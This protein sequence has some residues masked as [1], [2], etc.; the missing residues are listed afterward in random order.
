MLC[1]RLVAEGLRF[2][3]FQRGRDG[4]FTADRV[5]LAGALAED[6]KC[7]DTFFQVEAADYAGL[8]GGEWAVCL[9]D[10]RNARGVPTGVVGALPR[11]VNRWCTVAGGVKITDG[12]SPAPGLTLKKSALKAASSAVPADAGVRAATLSAVPATAKK[13]RITALSVADGVV[14]LTVADTVPYLTYGVASGDAPDALSDDAD[15]TVADGVDGAPI[16][17]EAGADGE[18]RFFKVKRAE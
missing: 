17:L 11:R 10:T 18:S 13:P 9:V 14:R 16:E 8:E 2:C 5:V 6:G 1:A 4:C 15:A 7:P 12:A 3:R